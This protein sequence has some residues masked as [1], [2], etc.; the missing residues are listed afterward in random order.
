M[1][2]RAAVLAMLATLAACSSDSDP[3]PG[4][5][6]QGEARQLDAAAAMLDARPQAPLVDATVPADL[7]GDATTAAK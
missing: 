6:T 1:I 5:V 7:D 2:G 4:G 3:G